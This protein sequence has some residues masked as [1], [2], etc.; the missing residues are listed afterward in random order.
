M[1]SRVPIILYKNIERTGNLR[2]YIRGNLDLTDIRRLDRS[3]PLISYNEQNL[4]LTTVNGNPTWKV[5]ISKALTSSAPSKGSESGL[6]YNR[7][8]GLDTTTDL[9]SSSVNGFSFCIRFLCSSL[10]IP[11]GN[12]QVIFTNGIFNTNGYTLYVWDVV[13]NGDFLLYFY[14]NASK[15]P[16]VI[17]NSIL[18]IDTWYTLCIRLTG[19][20]MLEAYLNGVA[21]IVSPPL[22]PITVA[23]TTSSSFFLAGKTQANYYFLGKI[24]EFIFYDSL[25]PTTLFTNCFSTS[26]FGP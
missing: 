19:D 16:V 10:T 20:N 23:P 13:P 21:Q 14:D 17:S 5:T 18:E 22:F 9:I 4:S 6:F 15:T 24:A 2:T 3:S 11:S 8:T 12:P 26:P 25:L 7:K 1:P